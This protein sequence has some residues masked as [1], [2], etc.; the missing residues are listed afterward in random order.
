MSA[1]RVVLQHEDVFLSVLLDDGTS[2]HLHHLG[3]FLS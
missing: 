1:S 3:E 2:Y